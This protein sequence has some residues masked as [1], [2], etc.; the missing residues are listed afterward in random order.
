MSADWVEI[1]WTLVAF[2]GLGLSLRGLIYA[3]GDLDYLLEH[4]YNGR[5]LI[6]AK[7]YL[8]R[9]TIR[10]AVQMLFAALGILAMLRPPPPGERTP[11]SLFLIGLLVLAA[12]LTVLNTFGDL[13][14]RRRLID[15]WEATN[16]S[17]VRDRDQEIK[18]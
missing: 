11:G 15:H 2:V 5:R 6:I 7:G 16:L 1:I 3:K 12:A 14:D 10:T 18:P 13:R 17:H 8:R 9:E 4:H